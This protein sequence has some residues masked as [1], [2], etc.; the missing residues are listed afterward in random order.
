MDD[1]CGEKIEWIGFRLIEGCHFDDLILCQIII[2]YR[3]IGVYFGK[4]VT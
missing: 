3:N 1:V 4:N 2:E